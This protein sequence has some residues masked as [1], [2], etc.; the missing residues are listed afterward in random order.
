MAGKVV[1]EVGNEK[2]N[3]KHYGDGTK[4]TALPLMGGHLHI[5]TDPTLSQHTS[6]HLHH[7]QMQTMRKS[8]VNV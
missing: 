7:E 5:N 4:E 3:G 8:P 6:H 2:V 1:V